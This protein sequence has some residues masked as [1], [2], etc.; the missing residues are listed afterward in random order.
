VANPKNVSTT[1][2]QY[3]LDATASTAGNGGTLTYAWTIPAGSPAATIINPNTAT[4]TVQF[5]SGSN[6]YLF[7]LTVTDS[8]GKTA[9][10]TATIIYTGR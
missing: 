5:Q 2:K 8:N 7:T 1:S 4:P 9:T 6:T 10:D 3:Q